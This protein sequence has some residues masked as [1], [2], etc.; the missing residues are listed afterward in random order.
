MKSYPLIS[1]DRLDHGIYKTKR[2]DCTIAL[3]TTKKRQSIGF[4]SYPAN[5][6][7]SKCAVLQIYIYSFGLQVF[8]KKHTSETGHNPCKEKGKQGNRARA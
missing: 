2:K 7:A 4:V 6:A 5:L 8:L 1:M 3:I